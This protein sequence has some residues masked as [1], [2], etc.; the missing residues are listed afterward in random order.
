MDGYCSGVVLSDELYVGGRIDLWGARHCFVYGILICR[1]N[2][3][4]FSISSS[5]LPNKLKNN[6]HKSLKKGTTQ[7]ADSLMLLF[8]AAVVSRN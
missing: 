5:E 4:R 2:A 8:T 3:S 1:S 7:D 6:I